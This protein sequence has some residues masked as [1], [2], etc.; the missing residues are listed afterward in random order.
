MTHCIL[1]LA[2]C[3]KL[4]VFSFKSYLMYLVMTSVGSSISSDTSNTQPSIAY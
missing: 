1:K 3:S 4:A 2:V